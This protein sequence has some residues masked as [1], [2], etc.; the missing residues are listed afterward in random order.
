MKRRKMLMI[1]LGIAVAILLVAGSAFSGYYV[2][3]TAKASD[4]TQSYSQSFDEEGQNE[5]DDDTDCTCEDGT[6]SSNNGSGGTTKKTQN[7]K[8]KE[9]T[10]KAPEKC[11]NCGGKGIIDCPDCDGSGSQCCSECGG[12][13]IVETW[14]NG[15]HSMTPCTNKWCNSGITDCNTCEGKGIVKCPECC[16]LGYK[17]SKKLPK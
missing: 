8:K 1:A 9:E 11:S 13:E 10:P 5:S 7:N 14:T 16:G 15:H 4:D 12:D 17:S 6:S 3:K 2:S